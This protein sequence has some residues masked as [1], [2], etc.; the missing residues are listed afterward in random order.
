MIFLSSVTNARRRYIMSIAVNNTINN[1]TYTYQ[2][3]LQPKLDKNDDSLWSRSEVQ[4]YA[5]SY[6]KATGVT[7]DVD[8]IMSTYGNDDGYIDVKGQDQIKKDDALGLSKLLNTAAG[9]SSSAGTSAASSMTT[10]QKQAISSAVENYTYTAY[11]KLQPKLDKN[12]DGRWSKSELTNYA[13]AYKKA[14]GETLDVDAIMKKYAG[15]SGYIDPKNQ[16]AMKAD[17][18]LGLSKLESLLVE[19]AK[20]PA[21]S[22]A[23]KTNDFSLEELLKTMSPA[24]KM[25]FS[26]ML[27]KTETMSNLLNGFNSSYNSN[28]FGMYDIISDRN[29]VAQLY[30]GQ[31][32]YSSSAMYSAMAGQLMNFS[33]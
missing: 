22:A 32:Q 8:K 29:T 15:P 13:N 9:T 31:S 30:R 3:K 20:E 27:Q 16:A 6:K 4:S 26:N 11:G 7:L 19:A 25:Y 21:S 10:T 23:S 28:S 5:D 2:S 14:T 17:D 24:N 33:I 12:D 1:Y 18:A